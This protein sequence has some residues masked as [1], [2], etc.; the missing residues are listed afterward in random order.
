[1][2]AEAAAA[3]ASG[4]ASLGKIGFGIGQGIRARKLAKRLKDINYAGSQELQQGYDMAKNRAEAA[5]LYGLPGQGV[6][7]NQNQSALATSLRRMQESQQNPSAM[8]GGLTAINQ[9]ALNTNAQLALN[10]ANYRASN[11]GNTAN[12]FYNAGARLGADKLTRFRLNE[13]RKDE[14]ARKEIADLRSGSAANIYG[15]VDEM[16]KVA[17]AY[18]KKNK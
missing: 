15:G 11:M 9:N 5:T 12:Q 2:S 13:L 14:A 16:S 1:M 18:I 10:A 8:L 7:Q 3:I 4:V 17:S 6:I